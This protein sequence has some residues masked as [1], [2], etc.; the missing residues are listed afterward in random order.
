[1][2]YYAPNVNLGPFLIHICSL[3]MSYQRGTL[4]LA[5][6]SNVTLNPAL[7]KYPSERTAPSPDAKMFSNS[8]QSND[9]VDIWR[10]L[11]PLDKD[12]THYFHCHHSP[13]RIDHV[14]VLQKHLP[15]VV[16]ASILAAP[17]LDHDPV[18]IVCHYIHTYIQTSV[19]SLGY[20]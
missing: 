15:L 4:L 20:E 14:F 8:L 10:E 16:L 6:D 1:M 11:H 13:S 9:L 18:L 3:L 19:F 17:W 12:Y 2:T 7:D 5:G